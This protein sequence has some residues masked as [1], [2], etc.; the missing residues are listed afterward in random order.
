MVVTMMVVISL[1]VTMM[2]VFAMMVF[3]VMTIT[4][5]AS[6]ALAPER[7]LGAGVLVRGRLQLLVLEGFDSVPDRS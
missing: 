7:V 4:M 5:T 1:M 6:A 3:M 2:V